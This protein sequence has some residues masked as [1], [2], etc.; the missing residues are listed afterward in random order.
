MVS[1]VLSYVDLY[2]QAN[3]ATVLWVY[4]VILLYH[5]EGRLTYY[6]RIPIYV[7]ANELFPPEVCLNHQLSITVRQNSIQDDSC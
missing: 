4:F 3:P 6:N 5:R 1:K 2:L 7:V